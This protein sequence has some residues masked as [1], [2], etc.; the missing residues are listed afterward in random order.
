MKNKKI[1][2]QQCL[3]FLCICVLLLFPIQVNASK[4]GSNADADDG[5]TA[6]DRIIGGPAWQK[7]VWLV[8]I[9]DE[10]GNQLTD[11]KVF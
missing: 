2:I 6:T 4:L 1:V 11:T 8:Y 3:F 10:S 5:G 9:I 7:T